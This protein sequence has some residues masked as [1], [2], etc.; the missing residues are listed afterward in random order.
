VLSSVSCFP[1]D[2]TAA[3]ELQLLAVTQHFESIILH[4]AS[5]GIDQD[6]NYGV[7]F[8]LNEYGFHTIVKLKNLKLSH[9]NQGPSIVL[10]LE[11][12]LQSFRF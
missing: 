5:P 7:W 1:D 6:S 12:A 9:H 3:W 11:L 4:I 8:P 10:N 2:Y